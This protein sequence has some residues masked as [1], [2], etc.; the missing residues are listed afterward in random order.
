VSPEVG[1]EWILA[2]SVLA[3]SVICGYLVRVLLV[4]RLS[5]AFARTET[6]LDDLILASLKAH[7]PF[8]FLLGGLAAAVRISPY[9]Q[10]ASAVVERICAAGL[11]ISLSLAA[12]GLGGALLARYTRRAGVSFAATSLTQNVLRAGVLACGALLVLANLGISIAPLLTA[13]G[14]GSL[15]VALAL[16]PTLSNLFAGLH[17]ALARPIRVGD[18][19][20]LEGGPRG[21]VEDIGWRATRIR[22]LPNDSIVVPN[23]RVADMI[24]KNYD[25]PDP[26]Q[27]A[28]VPVGVA[29]GSDLDHVERVTCE[30]ARE[31][32]RE[33]EGGVAGFEPF[34]RYGRFGESAIELTVVLRVRRFA[35]QYLVIH[36]FIK[37]LKRRYER[38]GIEIPFPQRVVRGPA[39][40]PGVPSRAEA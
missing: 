19:V 10:R 38:E 13:L 14:V 27:A 32:L 21:Y 22:E 4:R 25:L 33:V 35:D 28:L 40:P 9:A 29:Y 36:E 1:R 8:W 20:E 37:R 30:V 24:V 17:I 34:V 6:D 26:E 39:A 31:T 18:F 7:V 5:A 3:A 2:A 23:A 12:A 15:A 16:K 11:A